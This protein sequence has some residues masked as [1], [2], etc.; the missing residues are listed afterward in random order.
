[1]QNNRK[2]Q[3][4]IPEGDF[5]YVVERLKQLLGDRVTDVHANG[6]LNPELQRVYKDL[7]KKSVAHFS[8]EGSI[9]TMRRCLYIASLFYFACYGSPNVRTRNTA[10]CARVT[11]A[12]GQYVALPQPVAMP[13][14]TSCLIHAA[15]Q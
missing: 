15:A 9:K 5:S 2:K 14:V 7:G 11:G 3:E 4:Q 6:T 10:I 12:S 8:E 13:S 1:M